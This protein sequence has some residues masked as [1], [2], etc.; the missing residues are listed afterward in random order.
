ML[1]E[2]NFSRSLTGWHTVNADATRKAANVQI[3]VGFVSPAAMFL[4]WLGLDWHA[5]AHGMSVSGG[6]Y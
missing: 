3:Q 1:A 4:C 6:L 5:Y 2:K